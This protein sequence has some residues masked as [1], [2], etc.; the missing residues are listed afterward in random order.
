MDVAD[1]N[2][3]VKDGAQGFRD[4]LKKAVDLARPEYKDAIKNIQTVFVV[5]WSLHSV[6]YDFLLFFFWSTRRR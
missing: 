6:V 5:S 1:H 3:N 4:K 2:S